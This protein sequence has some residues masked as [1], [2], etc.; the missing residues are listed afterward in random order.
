MSKIKFLAVLSALALLLTL[1]ALA[2]GQ[3]TGIPPHVFTGKAMVNG[4][5]APDGTMVSAMIDGQ[6]RGSVEVMDGKYALAVKAGNGTEVSFMVGDA[7][8]MEKG[9]WMMGGASMMDLMADEDM[10][11]G[12]GGTGEP[13]PA[14]PPGARG[15]AGRAV[16]PAR[17]ALTEPPDRPAPPVLPVPRGRL[18][19]RALRAPQAL[20]G[21]PANPDRRALPE[22]WV[23]PDLRAATPWASSPW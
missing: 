11:M 9:E 18:V 14:G 15:P 10:M 17:P 3:G 2:Y 21:L 1:P 12:P 13:G 19:P 16:L 8:V 23:P 4:Q 22:R 20:P 5:T 6:E 7:M